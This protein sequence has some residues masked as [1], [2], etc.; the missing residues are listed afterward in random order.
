M[1]TFHYK[2]MIMTMITYFF[3]MFFTL[4]KAREPFEVSVYKER[5]TVYVDMCGR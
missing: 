4:L 2:V 3:T 5:G 1:P